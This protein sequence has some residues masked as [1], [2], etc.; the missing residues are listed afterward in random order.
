MGRVDGPFPWRQ[1]TGNVRKSGLEW[2]GKH[3]TAIPW[4]V[5]S[6]DTMNWLENTYVDHH[7]HCRIFKYSFVTSVISAAHNT[8]KTQYRHTFIAGSSL[9]VELPTFGLQ[10]AFDES[11]IKSL[12]YWDPPLLQKL[13][14][15]NHSARVPP[16]MLHLRNAVIHMFRTTFSS[17]ELSRQ[18]SLIMVNVWVSRVLICIK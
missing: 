3:L 1:H 4:I 14:S 7:F 6:K 15:Y 2:K 17:T 10:I 13:L 5:M 12:H 16:H 9:S 8:L 18:P 11:D